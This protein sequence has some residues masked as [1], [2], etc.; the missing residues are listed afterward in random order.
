M[1]WCNFPMNGNYHE[2]SVDWFISQIK[3]L[4]N[5]VKNINISNL[6][7]VKD[8]GAV[9]DGQTDDLESFLLCEKSNNIII[10]PE[11]T[12]FLSN[13]FELKNK[14]I[15]GFNATLINRIANPD[16][17]CIKLNGGCT[18]CGVS[19]NTY[20][21]CIKLAGEWNQIINCK[22]TTTPID[23]NAYAYAIEIENGGYDKISF[24]EINNFIAN[25]HN[26]DGIHI[27]CGV[28]YVW[29][30][31][32]RI[33]SQDD[34]IAINS[35]EG[36][37]DRI[38]K[39]IYVNNCYIWANQG[40]R[41]Y[42]FGERRLIRDI[43]IND[44]IIDIQSNSIP[45]VR[46]TN[47]SNTEGNTGQE[48]LWANNLNINGCYLKCNTNCIT[49]A[50]SA[51]VSINVNNCTTELAQ[52]YSLLKTYNSNINSIKINEIHNLGSNAIL[53]IDSNIEMILVN[54]SYLKCASD[55]IKSTNTPSRVSPNVKM[56]KITGC[57]HTNS[58]VVALMNTR[59]GFNIDN[60]IITDNY[61][62]W[63]WIRTYPNGMTVT[64]VHLSGNKLGL[65]AGKYITLYTN[66]TRL[67]GGLIEHSAQGDVNLNGIGALKINGN[68]SFSGEPQ[69]EIGDTAIDSTAPEQWKMKF[70]NGT[71]WIDMTN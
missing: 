35:G 55:L 12:Y 66:G 58:A 8:Y 27:N 15:L 36:N 68:F 67:T 42:G 64:N 1:T 7:T 19:F 11:G 6:K 39:N 54:N 44:C 5:V 63:V 38:L 46:I 53:D 60:L 21:K 14:I 37:D 65:N 17:S 70:Y 34:A 41:I 31:N 56:L 20:S 71:D 16:T 28:W 40:I 50:N 59:D 25:V 26:R 57:Y 52:S 45:C 62:P 18:I 23:N 13:Q 69:A 3:Y 22:F 33:E 32:C 4:M 49:I 9:G 47:S 29:I 43:Y 61:F 24:C 30:E 48:F 10:I 51:L 2:P